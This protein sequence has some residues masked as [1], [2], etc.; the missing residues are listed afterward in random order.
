MPSCYNIHT[1]AFSFFTKQKLDGS[2]VLL[3]DIGSA[4]VGTALVRLVA[5]KPPH[6]LATVREDIPFQETLSSAR[7]L[8]GMLHALER[9]LKKIQ[10][11]NKGHGA[12]MHTFCTLSSP[13]FML[14]S[15]TIR[16]SEAASFE[17]TEKILETFLRE[18]TERLKEELKDTLPSQD[19][20]IIEQKII[21]MKLNGYEIKDPY[22]QTT[23][24]MELIATTGLSSQRVIQGIEHR[25]SQFFYTSSVHFG[26]FP[27]AAFSAIRDIFP[28]EQDFLFL[29]ITGEATDVSLVVNDILSGTVSFPYGKNFFIREIS[30]ELKTLHQEA[31]TLFMMF[32]R[33]TL[34]GKWRDQVGGV[35]PHSKNEWITR[36]G[37][38]LALFSGMGVLP[39]KV[40]FTADTEVA[41][42]F[43]GLIHHAK[44]EFSLG[45]GFD[46]VH[47][48]QFVVA[49][50]VSFESEVIRDPFL[51]V[52]A[53]FAG[54]II[55]K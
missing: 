4:S 16:I 6:I 14:K 41:P 30:A 47:L 50:Y 33:D 49:K 26:S 22:G 44:S 55:K 53:L 11:A 54:K 24:Q 46:V 29:D 51:V 31:A 36:F 38:A 40:F 17:V 1:M 9:A 52:E 12:P 18:D 15:R 48:D 3:I 37:K 43:A 32:L 39:R 13:W 34:E 20:E 27:V 8:S 35:L 7:F 45:E 23:N 21:Q 25:I 42:F 5:G 2:L 28:E 19:I 10:M